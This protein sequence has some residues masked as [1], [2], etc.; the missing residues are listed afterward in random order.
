[1]EENTLNRRVAVDKRKTRH[2]AAAG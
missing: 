2:L 1:V